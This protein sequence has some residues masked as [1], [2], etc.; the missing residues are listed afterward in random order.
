MNFFKYFGDTRSTVDLDSKLDDYEIE[1]I[2]KLIEPS[3]HKVVYSR[4]SS[5]GVPYATTSCTPNYAIGITV[6]ETQCYAYGITVPE[7]QCYAYG[8]RT[9]ECYVTSE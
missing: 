3:T 6:P 9:A 7:T 4:Y 2:N 1:Q 5:I 8:T